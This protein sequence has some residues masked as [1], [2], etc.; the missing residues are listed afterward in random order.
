MDCLQA[1]AIISEAIDRSP[2]DAAV[3][4]AAK[5]HCRACPDCAGY[6]RALNDVKRAPLP[7]PP[8]DLADRIMAAVRAE[9]ETAA[10]PVVATDDTPEMLAESVA[11]AAA[12]EGALDA[13]AATD[14][15]AEQPGAE[16]PS[17]ADVAVAMA[18]AAASRPAGQLA[19]RIS[20]GNEAHDRRRTYAMLGTAAAVLVI[21]GAVSALGIMRLVG[22]GS[23]SASTGTVASMQLAP[24]ASEVAKTATQDAAAGAAPTAPAA[25]TTATAGYVVFGGIVYER[26]G[27]SSAT[28][29]SVPNVGT[30]RLA[31][32]ADKTPTLRTVYASDPKTA[33]YIPGDSQVLDSFTIVTRTFAG[34]TYAM[35][36]RDIT[37]LGSWPQL[38]LGMQTP[39]S[40][41]GSPVFTSDSAS[42]TGTPVFHRLGSTSAQGIAIAPGTLSADPAGGNPNW[43][44]WQPL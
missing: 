35:H 22:G 11:L 2:V 10:A 4:E 12:L 6:I 34:K 25:A 13:P 24:A 8:A 41:D 36:A 43:T 42:T 39:T 37:A 9:A 3:L 7:E 5:E 27:P 17:A 33:I 16:T 44:W 21:V 14:L 20:V 19:G 26:V 15:V 28:V 31:Y 1:Q 29:G 23:Q 18:T 32:S 40:A 30:I 38:P